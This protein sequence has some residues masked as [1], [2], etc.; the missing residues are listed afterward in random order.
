VEGTTRIH[1]EGQPAGI[2]TPQEAGFAAN[3][4]AAMRGEQTEGSVRASGA[5]AQATPEARRR[6]TVIPAVAPSGRL[7]LAELRAADV[8]AASGGLSVA[9][10]PKARRND[11]RGRGARTGAATVRLRDGADFSG[12]HFWKLID[13][14]LVELVLAGILAA[15][16][17]LA[18]VICRR[19]IVVEVKPMGGPDFARVVNGVEDCR[20]RVF[21]GRSIPCLSPRIPR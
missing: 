10:I 17:A 3:N 21:S 9:W 20:L 14:P 1:L 8:T 7:G 2:V 6:P 13:L 18:L 15:A 16:I 19:F 11:L 12:G 5:R 4:S